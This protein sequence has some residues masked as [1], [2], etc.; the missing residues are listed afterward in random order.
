MVRLKL[1]IIWKRFIRHQ[2]PG[3]RIPHPRQG[4]IQDRRV[5]AAVNFCDDLTDEELDNLVAQQDAYDRWEK[6]RS[7][8][9]REGRE[10]IPEQR[11]SHDDLEIG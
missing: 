3:C 2:P 11:K 4:L 9:R 8:S 7:Q 1:S 10:A 5:F 6:E